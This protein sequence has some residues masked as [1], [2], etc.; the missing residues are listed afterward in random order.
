[1]REIRY[2]CVTLVQN[3]SLLVEQCA[4]MFMIFENNQGVRLL[5]HAR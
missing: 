1:M 3:V 2:E 5:E 4:L